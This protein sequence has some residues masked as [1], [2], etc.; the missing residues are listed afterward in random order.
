M[1]KNR[2]T[3]PPRLYIRWAQFS[4]FCGLFLNGGHGERALWKRS[5]QELEIIRKF[6]WLHTELIPYMY[7]YVVEAHNG[8][9]TLQQPVKGKYHYLFGNDFLVAPIYEDEL[10]NTITLP[11]GKWR[12]LFNDQK[13]I[14]GPVVFER[15]FPLDE[16]PVYI[17]DGAIIP[18]DVKRAYTAFGD[19][20]SN[21]Y[22]T[23]LIY[24]NNKNSFTIYHNSNE[25]STSVRVEESSDKIEIDL[26]GVKRPHILRVQLPEKPNKVWLDDVQLIESEGYYYDAKL[27]K[28]IIKTSEYKMGHYSIQR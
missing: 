13:V 26:Q 23:L 3:I 19:E 14:E 24:P 12:Y 21:G 22:L 6:S 1:K 2:Q 18:M 10:F 25:E 20:N 15:E 5:T 7:H 4:T 11:A 28:L 8:G 27:N 16:Y 17:R 9:K